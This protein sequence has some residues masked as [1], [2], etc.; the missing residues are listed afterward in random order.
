MDK[1]DSIP[2]YFSR[3]QNT[4]AANWGPQSEMILSGSPNLEKALFTSSITVSSEVIVFLQGSSSTPFVRPWSTTTSIESYP[5]E[6]GRLV[7]MS[8]INWVKSAVD[9]APSIGNKV[10]FVGYWFILYC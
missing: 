5:D 8:I 9:F 7:M 4:L 6:V 10:S 3:S 2:K 1:A